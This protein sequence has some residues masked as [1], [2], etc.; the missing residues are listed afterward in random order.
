MAPGLI[1]TVIEKIYWKLAEW[2]T[3][4]INC[5]IIKIYQLWQD[6]G[7]SVGHELSIFILKLFNELYNVIH[8][9]RF[10]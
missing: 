9:N 4:I 10:A 8:G 3:S 5:V 6:P 1:G 7:R 2:P